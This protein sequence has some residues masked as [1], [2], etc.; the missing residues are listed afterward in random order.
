MLRG[1]MTIDCL[2]NEQNS[3]SPFF[4][5]SFQSIVKSVPG[6][7]I[8]QNTM[9]RGGGEKN[10]AGEKNEKWGSEEKWLLEKI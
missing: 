4:K 5:W 1:T 10:G 7:Y 2:D 6:V 9:A 3:I 8:V